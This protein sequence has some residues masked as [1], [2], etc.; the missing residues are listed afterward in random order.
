LSVQDFP[1]LEK[2]EIG[3]VTDDN[4]HGTKRGIHYLINQNGWMI[5]KKENLRYGYGIYF[6][7]NDIE[8]AKNFPLGFMAIDQYDKREILVCKIAWG[9]RG[10][11]NKL[12][13]EFSEFYT[14]VR[15]NYP[16]TLTKNEIIALWLER[17][18]YNTILVFERNN[19]KIGIILYNLKKDYEYWN[20]P[21]VKIVEVIDEDDW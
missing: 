6:S 2:Y 9:R 21:R 15:S 19:R 12:R 13:E 18:R 1:N 10:I 8:F 16:S 17:R 20:C 7:V 14:E 3:I 5:E 11:W 4:Y